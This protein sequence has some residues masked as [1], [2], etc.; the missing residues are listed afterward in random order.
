MM[1]DLPPVQEPDQHGAGAPPSQSDGPADVTPPPVQQGALSVEDDIRAEVAARNLAA[2]QA[3]N[4]A[5]E[6]PDNTTA[7]MPVTTPPAVVTANPRFKVSSEFEP[8]TAQI[9]TSRTAD[10]EMEELANAFGTIGKA[11]QFRYQRLTPMDL[12]DCE[13]GWTGWITVEAKEKGSEWIENFILNRSGGGRYELYLRSRETPERGLRHIFLQFTGDPRPA[14]TLGRLHWEQFMDPTAIADAEKRAE[15]KVQESNLVGLMQRVQELS[16][17][18]RQQLRQMEAEARQHG[19]STAVEMLKLIQPSFAARPGG[20]AGAI[21]A[22]LAPTLMAAL[23]MMR[24]GADKREERMM[25]MMKD[26]KEAGKPATPA[27]HVAVMESMLRITEKRME[28]EL[29]ARDEVTSMLIKQAMEQARA[30]GDAGRVTILGAL[31]EAIREKGGDVMAKLPDLIAKLVGPTQEQMALQRDLAA[32]QQAAMQMPAAPMQAL[33]PAPIAPV[34]GPVPAPPP[35]PEGEPLHRADEPD[36]LVVEQQRAQPS[37]GIPD[38]IE[39]GR[40]R[41]LRACAMF[42]FY[43]TSYASELADV[44]AVWEDQLDGMPPGSDLFHFYALSPANVRARIQAASKK[45]DGDLD[46]EAWFDGVADPDVVRF[47]TRLSD[48][49]KMTPAAK[50]WMRHVLGA[51]PWVEGRDDDDED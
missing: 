26:L 1:A 20:D 9:D 14:T 7:S 34:A 16:A 45:P 13:M 42:V 37:P 40:L 28:S 39:E 6:R 15:E 10:Q 43:L 17:A 47:T 48:Y 27:E 22:A 25:L 51:A 30:T 36:P 32:R 44:E 5:T 18:E 50:E 4:G 8:G 35:A 21:I 12:P 46:I 49:L 11:V 29:K 41:S 2:Q 23:Q 19:D 33:Q 3:K 24:D 31:A 38:P